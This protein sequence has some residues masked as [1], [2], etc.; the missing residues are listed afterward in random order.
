MT[1]IK[2]GVVVF[3]TA[4]TKDGRADARAWLKEKGFTPDRARLYAKDGMVLVET[5]KPW[6]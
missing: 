4:D 1:I 6:G 5:L 3:A 2:Q